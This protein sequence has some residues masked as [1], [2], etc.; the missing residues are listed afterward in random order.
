[1]VVLAWSATGCISPKDDYKDFASRPLTER[2]ASVADVQLTECQVLLGQPISGLYYTSCLP[3]ELQI[4][5]ALASTLNVTPSEEGTTATLDMSFTPLKVD[6]MKMSDTTGPVTPLD[7]T[8]IDAN[9]AYTLDIGSLTLG[10]EANSLGR[11]L[12]AT[13]VVLRGKFQ[14]VDRSCAELDGEVVLINLKLF[15]DGDICIFQRAPADGT[16]PP[17]PEYACPASDLQPRGP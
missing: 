1:L 4:P 13:K 12:T 17:M 15:G 9:C 16:I 14:T 2:E 5:F 7:P 10:A 6:A 11:D 3:N 8:T